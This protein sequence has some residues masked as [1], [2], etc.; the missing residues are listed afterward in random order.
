MK[1]FREIF[2]ICVA[3]EPSSINSTNIQMSKEQTFQYKMMM[4]P[5][6][7]GTYP[8]EGFI[9]LVENCSKKV[10]DCHAIIEY[11]EELNDADLKRYELKLVDAP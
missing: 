11:S 6:D 10:D 7:I 1:T 5:F 3:F 9:R 2:D 8:R 4:R